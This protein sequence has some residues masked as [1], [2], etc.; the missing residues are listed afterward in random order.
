MPLNK[1]H[2][3]GVLNGAVS[4]IDVELDYT[5]KD[6]NAIECTFEFPL[7]DNQV[8]TSLTAMIG[9]K[10]IEAKI[11]DKEE[12]KEKYDDAIAGGHA[13]VLGEK[14]EKKKNAMTLKLGNLLP[15]Q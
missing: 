14:S 1:V 5:N 11:Q 10:V 2:I 15:G 9:D 12:A 4:T 7:T 6:K 3:K 13:A 8:V